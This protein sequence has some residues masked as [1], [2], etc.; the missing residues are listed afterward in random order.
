[1]YMKSRVALRALVRHCRA[2]VRLEMVIDI[3]GRLVDI[4]SHPTKGLAIKRLAA[5]ADVVRGRLA[6]ARWSERLPC[7][8]RE[9]CRPDSFFY[10]VRRRIHAHEHAHVEVYR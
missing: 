10:F 1:M 5:T 2:C 4:F 6:V 7:K 8:K 9:C 3:A